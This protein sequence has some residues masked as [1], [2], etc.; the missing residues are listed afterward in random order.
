MV[1]YL[2]YLYSDSMLTCY[3]MQALTTS[4]EAKRPGNGLRAHW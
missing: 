2:F 4:A 1:G 3:R